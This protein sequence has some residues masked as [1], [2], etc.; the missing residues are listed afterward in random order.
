MRYFSTPSTELLLARCWFCTTL[1]II[2]SLPSLPL[3]V[4]VRRPSCRVSKRQILQ[5][6]VPTYTPELRPL[7]KEQG[8]H[9][10]LLRG[11]WWQR[12]PSC[13]AFPR[14]KIE[15]TCDSPLCTKHFSAQDHF[16]AK[17]KV[18]W[19]RKGDTLQA[20]IGF[21]SLFCAGNTCHLSKRVWKTFILNISATHWCQGQGELPWTTGSSKLQVSVFPPKSMGA[22]YG[23][24]YII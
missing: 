17:K 2:P 22:M 5:I 10:A 19:A 7:Y 23:I 8:F 12:T 13:S 15:T 14:R 6:Q 1:S 24:K 11:T 16:Q 21:R 9:T 20:Y 4:G 18:P 3:W